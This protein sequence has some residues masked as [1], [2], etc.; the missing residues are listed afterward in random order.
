MCIRDSNQLVAKGM[1]EALGCAVD[2]VEDGLSAKALMTSGNRWDV[3]L[4]DWHLPGMDGIEVSRA[5]RNAGYAGP[6]VA[7][8]ASVRD[9]DQAQILA[10]G[11]SGFVGKPFSQK[12]LAIGI[13]EGMNLDTSL[14]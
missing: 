2:L 4:M 8:T 6:I 14:S 7:L 12:Q 3:V 11:M 1:L 9:E 10:A 5:A 13:L